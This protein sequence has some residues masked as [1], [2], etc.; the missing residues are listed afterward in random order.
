M[1]PFWFQFASVYSLTQA[2]QFLDY[3]L[4]RLRDEYR[5]LYSP[6]VPHLALCILHVGLGQFQPYRMRGAQAPPVHPRCPIFLAAG[7]MNRERVLL[8]RMRFDKGSMR[9]SG[10]SF[11]YSLSHTCLIS[12]RYLNPILPA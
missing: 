8:S 5:A 12:E 10:G 6:S 3:T 9:V 4:L 2:A 1:V 11:C 7:L